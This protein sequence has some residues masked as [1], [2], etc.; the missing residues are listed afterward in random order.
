[1]SL[2]RR[3]HPLPHGCSCSGLYLASSLGFPH[4]CSD[5]DSA[6]TAAS[7]TRAMESAMFPLLPSPL[8]CWTQMCHWLRRLKTCTLKDGTC[9]MDGNGLSMQLACC[10]SPRA[11]GGWCSCLCIVYVKYVF[12]SW[13]CSC[14]GCRTSQLRMRCN[15]RKGLGTEPKP[16]IYALTWCFSPQDMESIMLRLPLLLMYQTGVP[17]TAT[18]KDSRHGGWY[19]CSDGSVLA[20]D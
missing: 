5:N 6:T 7:V 2:L 1:M 11:W 12:V 9:A 20:G 16:V 14:K 17:L 19:L 4:P 18:A 10:T 13:Y 8:M 3:W 15:R